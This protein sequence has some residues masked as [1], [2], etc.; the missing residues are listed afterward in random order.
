MFVA[1]QEPEIQLVV[2]Q[3]FPKSHYVHLWLITSQEVEPKKCV[4]A[5]CVLD[6]LVSWTHFHKKGKGLV[7]CIYK[8]CPVVLYSVVQSH[9]SILSHDVLHHYLSSNS[10]LENDERELRRL[11]CYCRSCKNTSTVLLRKH[12]Y[13]TTGISRVHY[14][15]SDYII[16]LIVFQWD[17]VCMHSSPDPSHFFFLAEVGLACETRCW[18]LCYYRTS[19][20]MDAW[21]TKWSCVSF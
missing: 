11:F 15:K 9:C 6:S 14:L 21:C 8:P 20:H 4:W 12:T 2:S 17:R 7:N 3:L 10:C 19:L 5:G 16:Q 13:S 18:K 1:V